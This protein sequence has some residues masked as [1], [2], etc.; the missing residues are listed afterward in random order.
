[1]SQET[2]EHIDGNGQARYLDVARELLRPQGYLILT[3]PSRSTME[4]FPGGGRAWSNQPVEN[5][6]Y[7]TDLRDLLRRRGFHLIQMTSF[8]F[9]YGSLGLYR[10]ANSHKLNRFLELVGAHPIWRGALARAN[11]G[12]HLVVLARKI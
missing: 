1:M 3:T 5:W 11:F 12:L 9:G 7:A 10:L 8:V 4:A 2:I 6:L